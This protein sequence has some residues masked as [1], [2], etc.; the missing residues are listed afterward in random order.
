MFGVVVALVV[1]LPA[2]TA[3]AGHCDY[4]N[5]G[6]PTAVAIKTPEIGVD[7][8]LVVVLEDERYRPLGQTSWDITTVT[9]TDSSGTVVDGALEVHPG[10]SPAAWRPTSPWSP[11]VYD[12]TVTVDLPSF[13]A[14]PGPTG[15]SGFTHEAVVV[16]ADGP[17]HVVGT[18]ALS[19]VETYDM[20]PVASLGTLVC[21]DGAL[22]RNGSVQGIWCPGYPSTQLEIGEGHCTELSAT[23]WLGLDAQ[24]L[25]DG[26]PAPPSYSM[27]EVT[28]E[29]TSAGGDARMSMDITAPACLQF[30]LLDLVTGERTIHES[31]HGDAIA[32]QLGTLDLDPTAQLAANCSGEAYVCEEHGDAWDADA[33]LTWPYGAPFVHPS[34]IPAEDETPDDMPPASSAVDDGCRVGAGPAPGAP[35]LVALVLLGR[36]RR[37]RA[38]QRPA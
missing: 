24:V 3:Q 13:P 11:G 8:V 4:C 34:T 35:G 30:E 9:V 14:E 19:V 38:V 1:G 23:G 16:V 10:F 17:R 15:C 29:R 25:I 5:E 20:K 12:V 32:D 31:C 37:A 22:P 6:L 21:C 28:R 36:R 7:G 2:A 27:R 26:E 18:Q 33:C